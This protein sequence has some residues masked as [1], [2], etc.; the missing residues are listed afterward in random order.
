VCPEKLYGLQLGAL[1]L[2][3]VN[4]VFNQPYY[5]AGNGKL[6]YVTAIDIIVKCVVALYLLS[7]CPN[8]E[9]WM[10]LPSRR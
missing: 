1:D 4:V 8:S 9:F 5:N 3:L 10:R 6:G 7:S 2:T